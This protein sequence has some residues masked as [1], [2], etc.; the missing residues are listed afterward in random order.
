MTTA[1][2]YSSLLGAAVLGAA[3][4][5]CGGENAAAKD[6]D[7][8][9][10]VTM[11]VGPENITLVVR[12]QVSSG[13]GISGTLAAEREATVR[14]EISGPVLST[15]ADQGVRVARGTVLARLDDRTLQDQMLSARGA[16]TTA[17]SSLNLA[18]RELDRFTKLKEA[19][20]I[21]DR[22]YENV[23]LNHE[24]AQAAL[25]DAKARLTFAQKQLDDAQVRAPFGGI[26]SLRQVNAGDVVQPGGA[27]FTI[28]DPS[29]MRLE[30]AVPAAQLTALRIGAP[31]TFKV[32]GYPDKPFQGKISRINPQ[33]DASTG[34]VRVVVSI[35]NERGGLVGGLFAEGRVAAEKRQGLT[36]AATAVDVRGLRPVVMRIKG[37]RVER[38]EVELGLRDEDSERVEITQGV[39]AG[40][41]LLVGAAQGISA[42]TLV[43]VSAPTDTRTAAQAST[44]PK[45]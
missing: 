27:M 12:E 16:V 32:S 1:F 40:D 39:S 18:Q 30:G 35:P 7:S 3:L 22:E 4:A 38:V 26:V 36:A 11:T 8:A 20:A 10:P 45:S 2:R 21:A 9:A 28:I 33:A 25:A 15:H 42:G 23:K 17:T 5:A 6:A 41:T 24:A 31:V 44:S 43:K 14:A 37:G 19:G 34:Q 13:P 29:S